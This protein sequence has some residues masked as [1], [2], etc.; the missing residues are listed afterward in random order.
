MLAY[1]VYMSTI[2]RSELPYADFS[3]YG[4]SFIRSNYERQ[5]SQAWNG[6]F[7]MSEPNHKQTPAYN[8]RFM[9]FWQ[10]IESKETLDYRLSI[11]NE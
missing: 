5:M 9:A 10:E 3:G 11:Y 7:I 1:R 4:A 6:R 2:N 8:E